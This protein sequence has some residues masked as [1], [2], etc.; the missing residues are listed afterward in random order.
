VVLAALAPSAQSA[1][2]LGTDS[3]DSVS[4]PQLQTSQ[5]LPQTPDASVPVP[6]VPQVQTP[7]VPQVQ[8][9]SVP[10]VQTPS[11]P[12]VHTPSV[13][14]PSMQTPSTSGQSSQ[15]TS[16]GGGGSAGSGSSSG[17]SG[18]GSSSSGGGASGSGSRRSSR[19]AASQS[20]PQARARHRAHERHVRAEVRELR[21]CLGS[22]DATGR[23]FLSLRAG[24]DG[25]AL[26]RGAAARELGIPRA[27]ARGLEQ[28]SLRALR[29]ACGVSSG[30]GPSAQ[31]V[32][33]RTSSMPQFQ[34]ASLLVA[35]GGAEPHELVDQDELGGGGG[36]GRQQVK[37]E[38]R[39]S[40]DESPRGVGVEPPAS[41]SPPKTIATAS[42][43][44]GGVSGALIALV[45][46]LALLTA[47][48]LTLVRN[49]RTR[50][51]AAG[52]PAENLT[53]ATAATAVPAAAPERG[54]ETQAA[55]APEPELVPA[56]D[57][58]PQT[59]PEP[60]PH[61]EATAAAAEQ[62]AVEPSR[63]Q[64]ATPAAPPATPRGGRD[65]RKAARPAAI[66]ASG[67][68]SFVARELM[69]RRRGGRRRR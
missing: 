32:A 62:P 3:V 21:G 12:S 7:S 27:A 41:H 5:Q 13:H 56:P 29:S 67:V 8:T 38:T 46:A 45:L 68:L 60:E 34:D 22:I 58:Q 28:R 6:Q 64:A 20:T 1:L 18:S 36:Q 23:R 19:I 16:G 69:R 43:D 2:G 66:A 25:P 49:R 55:Q 54:P 11:V 50:H 26:S 57:A 63:P 47:M 15:S 30:G 39:S 59:E 9:P 51:A 61:Q 33:E 4:V 42:S 53:A 24:L 17:A 35:T 48:A 31:T 65:Y 40:G 44:D 52:V 14:T 37:G 10:Q